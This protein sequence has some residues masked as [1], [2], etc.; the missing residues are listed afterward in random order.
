MPTDYF[1][2][3]D[4]PEF[5]YAQHPGR[6]VLGQRVQCLLLDLTA[7]RR[8]G[9]ASALE[10]R[11]IHANLFSG[12][13]PPGYEYYAGHYRG[14]PFCCLR[15]YRVGVQ[16]DPRVGAD[17]AAV[18]HLMTWFAVEIAAA[19]DAL[20]AGQ[21]STTDELRYLIRFAC[22]ALVEFLGI[23]PYANGNGHVARLL[24]WC[25]LGRYGYWPVRWSVE[26]RPP[27]PPYTEFIRRYRDGDKAPLELFV[28]AMLA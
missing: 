5:E 18:G 12:L 25:I 6:A 23:H 13:A 16:D 15:Y 27:D 26:P 19:L 28:A 9:R 22:A 24:I 1:H 2:P 3:R 10:T 11:P 4:C 21:R 17:P 14:E 8:E 20:D 7:G